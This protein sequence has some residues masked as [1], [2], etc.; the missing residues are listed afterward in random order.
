MSKQE[1][2]GVVQFPLACLSDGNGWINRAISWALVNY[3][4][5]Q[6]DGDLQLAADR[7][8]ISLKSEERTRRRFQEMQRHLDKQPVNAARCTVRISRDLCFEVRDGKGMRERDFRILCAMRSVIG[9]KRFCRISREWLRIRSIG[10]LRMEDLSPTEGACLPTIGEV[11]TSLRRLQGF[12]ASVRPNPW[13]T[14]YSTAG[15]TPTQLADA[16]FALKTKALRTAAD[17]RLVD[18]DLQ[19]R[20]KAARE[21]TKIK[22]PA[23]M[24]NGEAAS[25]PDVRAEKRRLER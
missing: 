4:E 14:Y 24:K 10:H 19:R 25:L 16:V 3:A 18:E 2:K 21:T 7:L 8:D 9:Q 6:C 11:R 20:I 5:A 17:R 12:Y 1:C 22:G 13:Q 15:M 23:P